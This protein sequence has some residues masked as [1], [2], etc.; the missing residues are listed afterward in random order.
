MSKTNMTIDRPSARKTKQ[1]PND[2]FTGVVWA[3]ELVP[4]PQA[5][6]RLRLNKVTFTPGGRTNWHTHPIA[7]VLHVLSGVGR[8]QEIGGPLRELM[9]GD[10]AVIAGGVKHWHGSAP[11]HTFVHLAMTECDDK[12]GSATWLEPVSEADYNA[13]PAA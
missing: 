9:P 2:W 5:P 8:V 11:G 12:G 3:D 6:S 4:A 13:K 1:Q 7:Q 10:T